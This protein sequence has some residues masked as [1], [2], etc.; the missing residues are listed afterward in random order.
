MRSVELDPSSPASFLKVKQWLSECEQNHEGCAVSANPPLPTRVIDVGSDYGSQ[1]PHLHLSDGHHGRYIT[2]SHVWGKIATLTTTNNTISERIQGICLSEMPKNFR[3]AV[4]VTRRLGFQYLW[5]DSLC[6][7]QDSA[8]DWEIESAKMSAVYKNS[9]LT[10][11]AASAKNSHVGFLIARNPLEQL[12][13]D[14]RHLSTDGGETHKIQIVWPPPRSGDNAISTR[15]WTLQELILSPRVVH[16]TISQDH[17]IGQM[18]WECQKHTE[19]E[20]GSVSSIF[21]VYSRTIKRALKL[22]VEDSR[23]INAIY[24]C[25]YYIIRQY[26][27][28]YLSYPSDK[29]PALSGL[30]TEIQFYTKDGYLAGLWEGDLARGLLWAASGQDRLQRPTEVY[31]APSWSWASVEGEIYYDGVNHLDSGDSQ[32]P[33]EIMLEVLDAEAKPTGLNPLGAVHTGHITMGGFLKA[34]LFSRTASPLDRSHAFEC[35]PADSAMPAGRIRFDE[36]DPP[37]SEAEFVWCLLVSKE[38]H[39]HHPLPFQ[40]IPNGLVLL[41]TTHEGMELFTRVG[42]FELHEGFMDWFDDCGDEM[43]VVTII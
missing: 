20:N 10:I 3:D 2:L 12:S 40:T 39:F 25:W 13:C 31:R 11:S 41:P 33:K 7:V 18:I 26:S 22:A 16:Y 4:I 15:A 14:L 21:G 28:R 38:E 30:A 42:V 24:K 32:A 9:S 8:T 23:S 19:P 27:T 35:A 43:Q 37:S 34:T 5:I 36:L 29:L 17:T 1:E 6:I